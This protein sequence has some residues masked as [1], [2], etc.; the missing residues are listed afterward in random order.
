MFKTTSYLVSA[1][2]I[3]L[4]CMAAPQKANAASISMFQTLYPVPGEADPVGGNVLFTITVPFV[5]PTFS[6]NLTSTVTANDSSNP[7]GGLT[8]T[9]LLTNDVISAH[10]IGR[11]TLNGFAGALTDASYLAPTVGR[12][13]TLANRAV[14]DVIGFNF[15]DGIGP[16]V[17][18]PGLTSSVLVVQ[19]DALQYITSFVS[20]I[21]GT[22]AN[23]PSLAPA[24]EPGTALLCGLGAVLMLRRRSVA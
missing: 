5:A 3:G 8:F 23:V 21:N 14:A 17:L 10:P 6:G 19:T 15:I 4:A 20:V 11:L 1:L 16:G 2:A 22:V 7:F 9:Y 24:P 13:P 12:I 18:S